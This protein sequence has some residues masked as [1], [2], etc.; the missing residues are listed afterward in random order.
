MQKTFL[1]LIYQ[2]YYLMQILIANKDR[3]INTTI[4][5]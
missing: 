3:K 1:F 2:K 4:K 5:N